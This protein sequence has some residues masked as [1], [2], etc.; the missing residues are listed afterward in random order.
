MSVATKQLPAICSDAGSVNTRLPP[1]RLD[2]GDGGHRDPYNGL[3][4]NPYII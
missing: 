1:G 4:I 2:G 3:C